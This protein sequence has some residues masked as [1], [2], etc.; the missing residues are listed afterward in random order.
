MSSKDKKETTITVDGQILQQVP[1]FVYLGSTFQ[2]TRE[3]EMD[4]RKTL[5]MGRSAVQLLWSIWKSRD[6]TNTTK[7]RLLK[8]PV[9]PIATYGCERWILTK[10]DYRR[11]EDFEMWCFKRQ[12]RISWTQRKTNKWILKTLSE[13]KQQLYSIKKCKISYYG[14]I[15]RK[16]NCLE[17]DI[18]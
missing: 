8:S 18:I 15:M 17:K 3:C 9:R 10:S 2:E 13:E 14:H 5:G 11:T 6:I 7:V 4:I 1:S 16:T 12:L